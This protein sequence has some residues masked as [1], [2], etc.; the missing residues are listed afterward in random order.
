VACKLQPYIK[1]S[2]KIDSLFQEGIL[3]ELHAKS[4]RILKDIDLYTALM[5]IVYS[6]WIFNFNFETGNKNIY[7]FCYILLKNKKIMF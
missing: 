1:L 4:T 6:Y 5:G 2:G 3:V 7:A